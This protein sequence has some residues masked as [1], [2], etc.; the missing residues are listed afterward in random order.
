MPRAV[1]ELDRLVVAALQREPRGTWRAIARRIGVSEAT[2]ACR[3][4]RL[5]DAGIVR[6]IGSPVSTRLDLGFHVLVS[7]SCRAGDTLEVARTLAR[8]ADVRFVAVVTGTFDVVAEFLVPSK[9]QLAYVLL[10]E[11]QRIR[12]SSRR[13]R[14]RSC[15]RTRCRRRGA[16]PSSATAGCR[17]RTAS[18]GPISRRRTQPPH[19][20]RSARSTWGSSSS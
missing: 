11:I 12:G 6:V 19:G 18:S 16:R 8:R 9:R 20:S 4:R 3:A 14:T 10:E 7:F 5:L 2:V 1:D 17:S 13:A 15:A